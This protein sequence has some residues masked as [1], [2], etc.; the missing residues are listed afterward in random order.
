[1][2]DYDSIIAAAI[3]ESRHLRGSYADSLQ[4][5]LLEASDRLSSCFASGHKVLIA[6]NGGSAADSQHFAAELVVRLTSEFDRPALPAIALSVDTSVVTAAANDYG[7]EQ[8]FAR[9]VEALGMAGDIFIGLS[10]SGRSANVLAA[11]AVAQ[12]RGLT[13]IGLFGESGPIDPNLCELP[14]LIPTKTT[15]R[16]QEEHIFALHL[17]VQLT[18]ARHFSK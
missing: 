15:M 13:T 14:L 7:Y 17:L 4:S 16:I 5:W 12:R 11:F 8:I 18:E 10:T 3:E 6:G 9:Q 2:S 1:M